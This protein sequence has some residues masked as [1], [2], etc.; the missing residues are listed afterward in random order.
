MTYN[1]PDG[2]TVTTTVVTDGVQFETRDADGNYISVV[3]Q[4]DFMAQ[5]LVSELQA[6]SVGA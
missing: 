3:T 2:S 4:P 5:Y 6:R 1:L